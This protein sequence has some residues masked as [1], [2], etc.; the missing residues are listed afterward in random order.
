[1]QKRGSEDEDRWP[2]RVNLKNEDKIK[3]F[4]CS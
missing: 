4:L 3:Q 1:M 2:S